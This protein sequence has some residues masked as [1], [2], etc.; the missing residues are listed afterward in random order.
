MSAP[1]GPFYPGAAWDRV[2]AALEDH[3]LIAA[4]RGPDRAEIHCPLPGH[5]HGDRDA[6]ATAD[7]G[8]RG[9]VLRC[10]TNPAEHTGEAIAAAIGLAASDLFDEPPAP[11]RARNRPRPPRPAHLAVVKD[12]PAPACPHRWVKV[13]SYPYSD[14]DGTLINRVTRKECHLCGGKDIR[15]ERTWPEDQRVLYR[16]AEVLEAIAGG[17]DIYVAEGEKDVDALRR[18]LGLV[19][20]TNPFGA[21]KWLPA[22]TEALRGA[23]R[24]RVIADRDAPGYRHAI[25]VADALRAIGIPVDVL[26]AA[27]GKDAA[28]HIAAGGTAGTFIGIDPAGRLAELLAEAS[29][30]AAAGAEVVNLAAAG[31]IAPAGERYPI[32]YRALPVVMSLDNA[33]WFDPGEPP[34]TIPAVLPH[35]VTILFSPPGVGKTRL[36]I[37]WE[38]AI[39][40]GVPW[41][42]YKP[43]DP[44]RVLIID[45]EN[46]AAATMNASVSYAPL[47]DLE[48][49]R[50]RTGP[51]GIADLA[52]GDATLITYWSAWPGE[53]FA[54]RF[55]ELEK[56][57]RAADADGCPY[58]YVRIDT[59]REFI[60]PYPDQ[61]NAYRWEGACLNALNNLAKD[62]GV[63]IVVVHHTNKSGEISGSVGIEG[64]SEGSYKINLGEDGSGMLHCKKLRGAEKRHWEMRF[65]G[66]WWTVVGEVPESQVTNTGNAARILAYLARSGDRAPLADIHAALPGTSV[67]S[68]KTTL[69]RLKEK[70]WIRR[71]DGNIWVLVRNGQAA[72]A[73]DPARC[74]VCNGMLDPAL[75]RNGIT[76]HPMCEDR[77]PGS[78]PAPEP[79]PP[80]PAGEPR[81]REDQ[82]DAGPEPGLPGDHAGADVCPSCG[83]PRTEEDQ[84]PTCEH[85][86]ASSAHWPATKILKDALGH[87]RMKPLPWIPPPGHPMADTIRQDRSMPQWQ[88]AA[89]CDT[90]AFAWKRPGLLEDFGPDAPVVVIDR[91]GSYMSALSSVRVAPRLL[92]PYGPFTEDPRELG[93][94]EQYGPR[95]GKPTGLA[96]IVEIIVP[97]WDHPELPHPLGR[98]ARPGDRL[99]IPS[100]QLEDIF[101]LH[102]AGLIDLPVVTDSAL[103]RRNTSLFEPFCDAVREARKKFTGDEKNPGDKVMLNAVKRSS[104]IAIRTLYPKQASSPHWRPDWYA[105]GV[106]ESMFRHW[107]TA[108][109]AVDA[110]ATLA[111]IGKTDEASFVVPPGADPA[112]YL[113]E[114]YRLG[115]GFG[116]VKYKPIRVRESAGLEGVDPARITPADGH[117][118]QVMISGPVPLRL[119]MV[120]RG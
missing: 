115:T 81:P 48:V 98:N 112:S 118:G 23:S 27:S 19:A 44:G 52:P 103:G 9:A 80:A 93:K 1:A 110:G 89:R 32:D 91:N 36:S 53:R 84:H 116:Q 42:G 8:D 106:G 63:A 56:M 64:S 74:P 87:S 72:P 49:D 101:N 120:R 75:I 73:R 43:A 13:A 62:L 39:A 68:V 99:V 55:A 15:P 59:L 57:L 58:K 61:A 26:E 71:G 10:H 5:A 12:A 69:W 40:Y 70:G 14:Q 46:G 92:F 107:Q 88:L 38:H 20:T 21:G 100:G 86:E 102:R 11:G 77:G 96:G 25:M 28:D 54:D 97:A 3:G 24:V 108:R 7:R 119:W 67:G 109:K 113:P 50:Q 117:P 51:P 17:S 4:M 35:G 79:E 111:G 31:I 65:E 83:E 114:P 37:Q 29:D 16:L 6:S 45:F 33:R 2:R 78:A 76:V 41:A 95:A 60:S 34:F 90:G 22:H 66:G 105:A 30:Q 104:S 85:A 94:L 82:A 47:G 18:D